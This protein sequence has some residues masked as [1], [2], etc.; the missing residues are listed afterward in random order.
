MLRLTA[1]ITV[2]GLISRNL[3]CL[4]GALILDAVRGFGVLQVLACCVRCT[5]PPFPR[6]QD[7]LKLLV[8]VLQG[9]FLLGVRLTQQVIDS[10]VSLCH[11]VV[12]LLSLLYLTR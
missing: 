4:V 7:R 9:L 10:P 12:F 3:S 5:D 1:C 11:P 6:G 2:Q 8:Q